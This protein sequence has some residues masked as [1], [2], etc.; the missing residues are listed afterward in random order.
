LGRDSLKY[1]FKYTNGTSKVY[2]VLSEREAG[3]IAWT[4]G[5]HLVSYERIDDDDSD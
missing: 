4:E 1:L 2:E 3:D 5:D